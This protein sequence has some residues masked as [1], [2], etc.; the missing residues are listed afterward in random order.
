MHM[1]I[2][3]DHGFSEMN[4]EKGNSAQMEA[5]SQSVVTVDPTDVQ[6]FVERVDG[7]TTTSTSS[8]YMGPPYGHRVIDAEEYFH[9]LH[10]VFGHD[11]TLIEA[12]QGERIV[13]RGGKS[14]RT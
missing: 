2:A 10:A 9:G 8:D 6:G 14:V 5:S 7:S 12:S 4:N 3:K 13:G 11:L 1:S